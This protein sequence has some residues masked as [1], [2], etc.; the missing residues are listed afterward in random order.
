LVQITTIYN[1]IWKEEVIMKAEETI[2]AVFDSYPKLFQTRLEVLHHMFI[3]PGNG[4]RWLNGELVYYDSKEHRRR[5]PLKAGKAHQYIENREYDR[6]LGRNNEGLPGW[7]VAAANERKLELPPD[8]RP[9]PDWLAAYNE[10]KAALIEAGV[11][12]G[13]EADG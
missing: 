9:K 3:V 8:A 6:I 11:P 4:Y 10:I 12:V 5:N 2:Q 1:I 13:G 7:I